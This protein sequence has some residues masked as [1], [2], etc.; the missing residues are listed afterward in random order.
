VY[1][2]T[3]KNTT[4]GFGMNLVGAG[5]ATIENT[6]KTGGDS[7]VTLRGDYGS[8]WRGD[9]ILKDCGATSLY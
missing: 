8:L 4:L 5:T 1:N 7:F 9:L 2:A 6:I 3:I